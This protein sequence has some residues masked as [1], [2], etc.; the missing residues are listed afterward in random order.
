M[1]AGQLH[2]IELYVSDLERSASF[3]SWF[4]TKLG[5]TEYQRWAAG[6]SY[7]LGSTYIVLVQVS[8][9]HKK[10]YNRCNVG[11]NHLAFQAESQAQV[12]EL[13]TELQ[14]RGMTIL[15]QDKHKNPKNSQHRAVYF[16]DPDRM[17]VELIAPDC[18]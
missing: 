13:T 6:R 8:E 15:Y 14:K 18:Q 3:W 5:Y 11:L 1:S 7:I 12:D 10:T 9:R 16:E 17:K 2:H 4:L